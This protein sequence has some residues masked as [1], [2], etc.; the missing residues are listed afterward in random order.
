MPENSPFDT[1]A[2]R[3]L[4]SEPAAEPEAA[5]QAA[6]S[7][8]AETVE[9][10]S[11]VQQLQSTRKGGASWFYWIAALSLVNT[12]LLFFGSDTTFGLGLGLTLFI[13]SFASGAAK[14]GSIKWAAVGLT[15]DALIIGVVALFGV[16]A[17]K[18]KGWAF[19]VGGVLLLL[20]TLF[21]LSFQMWISVAIHAWAVFSIFSGWNANKKLQ[22]LQAAQ[23]AG[24]S[25]WV[26]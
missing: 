22:Q 8:D 25:P 9:L 26:A 12:A 4:T 2:A 13:D 19:I 14:G 5:T 24:P 15:I 10:P 23:A 6:P 16:M 11:E 20:D 21:V 3:P 18:G 7:P 17:G 1:A